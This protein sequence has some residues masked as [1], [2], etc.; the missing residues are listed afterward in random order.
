MYAQKSFTRRL[1]RELEG[2]GV[3]TSVLLARTSLAKVKEVLLL[4]CTT[5][6]DGRSSEILP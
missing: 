1:E 3:L 6:R 5:A 4:D 2:E